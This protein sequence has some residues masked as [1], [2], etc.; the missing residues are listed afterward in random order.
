MKIKKLALK[1]VLHLLE[2]NLLTP[3][4]KE[5]SKIIK[6]IR[7]FTMAENEF[8]FQ[9]L[10]KRKILIAPYPLTDN[11]KR[12]GFRTQHYIESI[13]R[14]IV[15]YM[16][17]LPANGKFCD[18][19]CGAGTITYGLLKSYIDRQ[20]KIYGC[21][22][23]DYIDP[24]LKKLMHFKNKD[25]MEYLK[26]VPDNHFDGIME[27]VVLHHLPS[28]QQ[29]KACIKEMI[30]VTKNSGLIILVETIHK[31]WY[32]LFKNAVLDKL[33][34]DRTSE[35][36]GLTD[37]IPVPINFLSDEELTGKLQKSK[38]NIVKKVGLKPD[39][40][41]PKFHNIYICIKN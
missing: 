8:F 9:E 15:P 22:I 25:V 12:R 39:R 28:K 11:K 21:D 35:Q 1:R 40:A 14:A 4:L 34:N 33:L 18:I 6:T 24:K 19:G 29:Y 5:E 36:I 23:V 37:V 3:T 26:E 31:N 30:R 27:I 10:K 20:G 13:N 38:I 32:E 17:T 16:A 2:A 41:D 7:S